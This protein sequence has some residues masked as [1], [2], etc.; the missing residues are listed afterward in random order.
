MIRAF[1]NVN[2][3]TL[4]ACI[5]IKKTSSFNQ[6]RY[7]NVPAARESF[8]SGTS[9]Q[10][11]ED[12][13]NAWLADPKSVHVSWDSYFRNSAQGGP[14][15]HPPPSLSPEGRNEVGLRSIIGQTHSAAEPRVS[16]AASPDAIEEHLVVQN[17]I[18]GYQVRGHL[19]AE[20]DP[21]GLMHADN[22]TNINST[23]GIPPNFI[24]GRNEIN[25]ADLDKVFKLPSTTA[26]GGKEKSL[27]LSEI[28]KRLE[29]AY[30]GHIGVEYMFINNVERCNWIRERFEPPGA[31]AL[32]PDER[33]LTLARLTRSTRFE[34]FLSKKYPSEKRFGLE[35]C[36]S[37][38][39]AMK[40][41][42]DKSSE[43]GVTSVI[44]GM[45]HRGR[46][47]VLSNVCR[48]PLH[49]ILTQF[50]GLAAEDE[51]SGD[52]KYHLGTNV[53]RM[54]RVTKKNI[55]MSVV[56]NPSHLETVAPIAIGKTRAE[57][58]YKGDANGKEVM[59][60]ILH[61]DASLAGQGIC[62]ETMHLCELPDYTTHGTIHIVIN[63]QVGFTTSPRVARSSTYCTEVS[64]VVGA[65]IFHVNGDDP[66]SVMYVSKVAAEWRN[67][68][69]K[70][71]VIDLVGYR[72]Y[73]HNELDE[74]MFTQPIMYQ[75]IQKTKTCLEI[76]AARLI[77]EGIAKEEEV[78]D[79]QD[80]YDKICEEEFE[81]ANKETHIS[82]KDWI[83]SPWSGFFKSKDPTKVNPTGVT[84]GT[85][86]HIAKIF[87]SPPPNTSQFKLHKG[88][89][90]ILAARMEMVENK[91][92]DWAIGEALAFGSLLKEG[93]HVRVSGED[94]ERGTFS[95]RHH[96]LH[97]QTVDREEYRPLCNLYPDQAPYTICNSHLCEYAVVGFEHG[98]SL[99]NPNALV[100]WEAQ[101][102]DFDN[103]AQ[104]I[105]DQY[106][107]CGE[108]KW[109]RQSGMV[110]FLPHGMEGM[111]PEHSSARL[112]RFLQMSSD[113]PE[114]VPPEGDKF[115]V[116]QLQEANWI[117]ANC[118][119]P[120]NFFHILRRQI[121]LPFRKP[122][123]LMTPKSL[124]R[125]PACRSPF[126]DMLE[127]TE[128][129]RLIPAGGPASE[130]PGAVEKLMFCSGKVFYDAAKAI[131]EKEVESKIALARVEQLTPFPFD[132][133]KQECEK[134][135][136][137]KVVWLQEE[138]KNQGAWSYVQPRF[139]SALEGQRKVSYVGR[140][141][142]ASPATGNKSQYQTEFKEM[143]DGV[144]S[145][146]DANN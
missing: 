17:V 24:T 65:P 4:P 85:L 83:D 81:R 10:Y 67:K 121:A 22:I 70:D 36:D 100:I 102:G 146:G 98:Y 135:P 31:M 37:L 115:V 107:S 51:G 5:P 30:C 109:L 68:Y 120:A 52:V 29:T 137:A 12:M 19:W 112:E 63:N 132:L 122:L 54:N 39:P 16:S 28:I 61:G 13:Y 57:Q 125:L 111:G 86:T 103:V 90:R 145:L 47:N 141:V 38:I 25:G 114:I 136:E 95:H 48:Q 106:V 43:L 46:L 142:A 92:A 127:G 66:D 88:I 123:I 84:E 3:H 7:S 104:C 62:Y 60:I 18:R 77:K 78:K 1:R 73:G 33:R 15:Y 53:K 64:K 26:I 75:K 139:L 130:N 2:N 44:I 74:P 138:H 27:P 34:Y 113:D 14:G 79:V 32:T 9:A 42:I 101:F 108:A 116:T 96:V 126:S 133:V 72:R 129:K 71:V 50:S 40:A 76:Y 97:H 99:T 49:K 41:A 21:L 45:A 117:V 124:L 118:S 6:R 82:Y 128:F 58:F 110:M 89:E 144:T 91:V 8:L 80:K 94:V 143:I 69:Q 35:G 55:S 131:K 140:Q 23:G 105:I 134:Y 87:S 20:I 119:T 56:A 11:V 93:V 59:A